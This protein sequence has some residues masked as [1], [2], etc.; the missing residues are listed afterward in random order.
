[1]GAASFPSLVQCKLRNF[2][3][4][5]VFWQGAMPRLTDLDLTFPVRKTREI[6]GSITDFELGLGNLSSLQNV[7]IRFRS[8]D[9][10][11]EDTEEAMAVLWRAAIVHPNHPTLRDW[12][13]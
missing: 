13:K 5:V 10:S 7:L 3:P 1:V 4:P 2:T 12:R 8:E 9:D 11:E 6:A